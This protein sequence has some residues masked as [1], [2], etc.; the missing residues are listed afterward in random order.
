MSDVTP[1]VLTDL[2]GDAEPAGEDSGAAE[3]ESNW[4]R[5]IRW[6]VW[7]IGIT[8]FLGYIALARVHTRLGV[9]AFSWDKNGRE[10][11]W[12]VWWRARYHIVDLGHDR[13]FVFVYAGLALA[14]LALSALACWIAL[15]PD[16]ASSPASTPD[17]RELN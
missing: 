12:R 7:A 4:H 15:V 2:T 1:H 6:I 14:F 8:L 17:A 5:K 9:E 11:I 13:L 16:D 3:H 10:Y